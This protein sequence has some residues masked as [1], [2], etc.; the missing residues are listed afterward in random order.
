MSANGLQA[1]PTRGARRNAS[2]TCCDSL[3]TP[4]SSARRGETSQWSCPKNEYSKSER[5]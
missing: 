1:M 2:D 5:L 4:R 3:R